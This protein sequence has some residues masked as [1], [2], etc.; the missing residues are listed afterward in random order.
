LAK[1]RRADASGWASQLACRRQQKR[2]R[3][4]DVPP[5]RAF[6]RRIGAMLLSTQRGFQRACTLAT[7]NLRFYRAN[8]T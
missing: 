7:Y 6:W 4:P 8:C 2:S 3:I 5:P 1:G